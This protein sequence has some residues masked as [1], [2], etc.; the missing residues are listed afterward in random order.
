MSLPG[1]E[2]LPDHINDLPP[3]RQ[4]HIRRQPGSASPAEQKMLLDSLTQITAPSLDFFLLTLVGAVVIGTAIYLNEIVF[5]VL[6]VVTLPFLKPIFSLALFP[7]RL[8]FR[9]AIASLAAVLFALLT[10]FVSGSMA[11]WLQKT[12]AYSR[13]GIYRFGAPFWLDIAIVTVSTLLCATTLIQQGRVPRLVGTLLSYEILLPLAAAGYAFPLGISQLWPG[14]LLVGLLHLG[15][16][17]ILS[18]LVFLL[19]GFSPQATKGWLATAAA[20]VLTVVLLTASLVTGAN[21]A[22]VPTPP[23]ST[24][25]PSLPA[26]TEAAQMDPNTATLALPST[27]ASATRTPSPSPTASTTPSITPTPE[28]TTYW[29]VINSLTGVVLRESPDHDSL[30]AGYANDGEQV[31]ILETA[32]PQGTTLWFRVQTELGQSGWMIASLMNTHTP[33][34]AE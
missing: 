12:A 13:L 2:H 9:R 33:T 23:V 28:P 16:A 34:P 32:V 6:A 21:R 17:I 11:G 20:L 3:A 30:V 25:L 8:E 27:T 26:G 24:E 14:A 31:E 4:R 7:H 19:S 18:T 1:S 10:V 5:L 29:A 15:I 22:P